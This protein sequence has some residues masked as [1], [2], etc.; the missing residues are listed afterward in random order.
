MWGS[1]VYVLDKLIT[2]GKKLPHWKPWSKCAIYMG[3]SLI[4]ASLVPLVLNPDSGTITSAFHVI[5]D[6]W[7][8]TVPLLDDYAFPDDKWQRLFGDS[9]YQYVVDDDDDNYPLS[10]Q[11][12]LDTTDH[13]DLV[14]DHIAQVTPATPLPIPPPPA[15]PLLPDTPINDNLSVLPL[16]IK[17]VS[18]ATSFGSPPQSAWPYNVLSSPFNPITYPD[19]FPSRMAPP[20]PSPNFSLPCPAPTLPVCHLR[21]PLMSSPREPSVPSS[22]PSPSPGATTIPPTLVIPQREISSPVTAVIKKHEA[23]TP[24]PPLPDTSKG[25]TT[26]SGKVLSS[27]SHVTWSSTSSLPP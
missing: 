24:K 16:T 9:K 6:D 22:F 17:K 21:E 19:A 13:H 26:C 1:P 8:T 5:F 4:H 7:F 27:E 15:T 2:N 3:A 20:I 23:T 11:S 10:S 14:S 25:I 12:D 18:P